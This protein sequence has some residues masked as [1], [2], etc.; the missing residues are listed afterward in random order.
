[1]ALCA[2]SCPPR[3]W[4]GRP[5]PRWRSP[6]RLLA[7]AFLTLWLSPVAAA[8]V[9]TLDEA[10]AALDGYQPEL[11]RYQ[12]QAEAARATAV[13]ESSAPDPVLTLGLQNLPVTGRDA[14]R[15][16]AEDMTM[17]TLGWMQTVVPAARRQAAAERWQ[18][19]AAEAEAERGAMQ[20][21]LR[22]DVSLAWL[23][24]YAAEW[25]LRWQQ[26]WQAQL[27]AERQT[28]LARQTSTGALDVVQLDAELAM[29]DDRRWQLTRDSGKARAQLARWLGEQVT[30]AW[31]ETLPE[32]PPLPDSETAPAQHPELL[33]VARGQAL[34]RADAALARAEREPEWSWG[35][36]YGLRQ[37][38]RADMLSLQVSRPWPWDRAQRQDQR[39]AARLAEVEQAGQR[40]EA[41]RR[42][43]ATALAEARAEAAAANARLQTHEQR[44][45]PA[46]QARL[47]TAEAGYA[48]G[49][50]P[51]SVA[52]AARRAQLEVERD[53][54]LLQVDRARAQVRLLYLLSPLLETRP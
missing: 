6:R 47:A 45:M 51:L 18:A 48:A 39:L 46:A 30:R 17:T 49:R 32:L 8:P 26:R 23:D 19:G 12:H 14:F 38:G 40:Q 25:Q 31:P 2:H 34:A 10:L 28:A 35:L 20:Q 13:A 53:H 4:R 15:T 21:R 44:L 27:A 54:A 11:A 5:W 52:W 7:V 36:M 16:H 41:V 33:A 24:V 22:Q 9:L 37:D 1:M 50:Q 43:L 42:E 3:D 29:A